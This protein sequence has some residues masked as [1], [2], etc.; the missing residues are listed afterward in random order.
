MTEARAKTNAMDAKGERKGRNGRP[1]LLT[2]QVEL[3][4]LQVAVVPGSPRNFKVT[5]PGDLELAE[6]Y[7]AAGAK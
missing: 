5:Q 1:K 3:G 6:F 4:D 7:L 2:S